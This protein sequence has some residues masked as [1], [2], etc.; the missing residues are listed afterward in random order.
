[1]S[2]R[3]AFRNLLLLLLLFALP[4]L[5]W[6]AP[7]VRG[8]FNGN[9]KSDLLWRNGATGQVYQMP[10]AGTAVQPGSIIYTEANPAWQIVAIADFDG[11]NKADLL[12][13]NSGTGQLYL[14]LLDGQAIR[15]Q[16]IIYTE[17]NLA[18]QIVGCGDFNGDGRADLL[19]RNG[20]TGDVY[21]MLLNGSGVLAGSTIHN[22]PN[23]QWQ[24]Q[25]IADFDG[26]GK[27]DILWRNASTGQV[28]QMLMD[29]AAIRSQ[30]MIY[31]EPQADWQIVGAAD[32]NGD[33]RA[34]LLWRNLTSGSVYLMFMNGSSIQ[35]G[36]VVYTEA[37]L[38][39]QIVSLGDFDGDGRADIL[40]RN[41]VSGQ[42][43]QL[44]MDGPSIKSRAMIYTEPNTAWTILEPTCRP[45]MAR[46]S[47]APAITLAPV[48]Q[49][50]PAGAWVTFSAAASGTPAP[51]LQWQRSAD[52]TTWVNLPGQTG[53]SYA[54]TAQ[55]GD[56]QARFRVVAC[57]AGGTTNSQA[58]LLTVKASPF[59]LNPQSQTAVTPG[60]VTFSVAA[61][62]SP[63]PTF[64]WEQSLDGRTWTTI[65]GATGSTVRLS[66]FPSDNG[67]WIRARIS[68]GSLAG[69]VSAAAL[70]TVNFQ[71]AITTPPQDQMTV[72]GSAATFSVAV[73]GNPAPSLQWQ[74]STDGSTWTA[75]PGAVQATY[76]FTPAL[77]DSE[78]KFR[79]TVQNG[80]G[81]ALTSGTAK[82]RVAQVPLLDQV[83]RYNIT[84][85][86]NNWYTVTVREGE[87]ISLS[88]IPQISGGNGGWGIINV[89]DDAWKP[90]AYTESMSFMTTSFTANST[91]TYYIS[92]GPVLDSAS[93]GYFDLGVYRAFWNTAANDASRTFSGTK[94]SALYLT[95]GNHVLKPPFLE[96]SRFNVTTGGRV[97][98]DV[99]T[100]LVG[101]GSS[102]AITMTVYDDG[103]SVIASTSGGY[104]HAKVS[105]SFISNMTSVYYLRIDTNGATGG[106]YSL[107]ATGIAADTD[108]DNDGLTDSMEYHRGT[109][110][111]Q[112]DSNGDGIADGAQD[113]LAARMTVLSPVDNSSMATALVVTSD[114]MDRIFAART[115]NA[116][117]YYKIQMQQGEGLS[118]EF[119]QHFL[120]SNGNNGEVTVFNE[121]G[122]TIVSSSDYA[123]S[124]TRLSLSF[125]ANATGVYYIRCGG[126]KPFSGY[127]ELGLFRAYWNQGLVERARSYSGTAITALPLAAGTH[128]LKSPYH[129]WYRFPVTLGEVV[130]FDVTPYLNGSNSNQIDLLVTDEAGTVV[131]SRSG[132]AGAP[133]TTTLKFTSYVN[134]TYRLG[135][136][137]NQTYPA[138]GGFYRLDCTFNG[139]KVDTDE[140]AIKLPDD[141]WFPQ[142]TLNDLG[143]LYN[144]SLAFLSASLARDAYNHLS[145]QAN[146]SVAKTMAWDYTLAA[147][148]FQ[149][150]KLAPAPVPVLTGMH[151]AW[152]AASSLLDWSGHESYITNLARSS[153]QTVVGNK[154]I[155]VGG[156][157]RRVIAIA[158]RGTQFTDPDEPA[159]S[160]L[161][162]AA[163]CAAGP[164]AYSTD[165]P[166]DL[167]HEGFKASA[168][169]FQDL[170]G[171]IA[172]GSG[173]LASAIAQAASSGDLFWVTG[174]SLGGAVATIY[175]AR[176]LDRGVSR[177]NLVLYTF[178]A[179]SV[180][181]DHFKSVFF[182][183][184]AEAAP[185][186]LAK[187]LNYHRIR[188]MY[189]VIPY[190][191]YLSFL[192]DAIKSGLK[193]AATDPGLLSH[194][195][196]TVLEDVALS[197]LKD[198]IKSYLTG[199]WPYQHIGYQKVMADSGD[200]TSQFVEGTVLL[201]D[202]VKLGLDEHS[203]DLYV[204]RLQKALPPQ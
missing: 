34:D 69:V 63:A 123:P 114:M 38:D 145:W 139:V 21:V 66:I 119:S 197:V 93:S 46:T 87:G 84:S 140:A 45:Q 135:I 203:M 24:I 189:D 186:L 111:K 201:G 167:V 67:T 4:G 200:V 92:A 18:W 58:A 164:V 117:H 137:D 28:F 42:I 183:E 152:A 133:T 182:N 23:P 157:Q 32:F 185:S 55:P 132:P 10:M 126:V 8:D 128:L 86:K 94:A 195:L 76:S 15:N 25:A 110:P 59:T 198:F 136:L 12:W 174:H 30:G 156:R 31:T 22:E 36:A 151:P 120:G 173:T 162:L 99:A 113:I 70:L 159:Q 85:G 148:G 131:A 184:S 115:R 149:Q 155:T 134:G 90:V 33:G 175:A 191:A 193:D 147:Q 168:S 127:Y 199:N 141:A 153:V 150:L 29:G 48:S 19:W 64:T 71:V 144:P 75:I 165:D 53:A 72:L 27:A 161:D 62:G 107:D 95:T 102:G 181:N 202:R 16:A 192:T 83:S 60:Y 101:G 73:T 9:G 170:E 106:Y 89:Y 13:R 179:P 47:G 187:K 77:T 80:I 121:Q 171:G 109:D 3:Y 43:Y 122:I 96:W 158:F 56:D 2:K 5:A 79:V 196:D 116:D 112:Q 98:I 108:S 97:Q 103:G 54:F 124:Y 154:T 35:G 142:K 172:V 50:V 160:N 7:P 138:T 6:A 17:P 166:T 41:S 129:N 118:I 51:T 176:L 57:N 194:P 143:T 26:D 44:L 178:G 169:V 163:D 65:A 14:V 74:R 52:G 11:D 104:S 100:Y 125:T 190:T 91:G 1:V 177:D 68:N 204:N 20:T 130:Q 61:T 180:G 105:L 82:L 78:Q 40:W 188:N 39:W 81:S 146:N 49:T 88:M 37:N